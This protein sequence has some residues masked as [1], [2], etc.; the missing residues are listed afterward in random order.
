[1]AAAAL[2]IA[3]TE[4]SGAV[5]GHTASRS[6]IKLVKATGHFQKAT[7]GT[8]KA[9]CPGGYRVIGGGYA[10]AGPGGARA[11]TFVAAPTSKDN[12]YWAGVVNPGSNPLNGEVGAETDVEAVAYCAKVGVPIVP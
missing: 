1:V 11:F 4:S 9:H 7:V 6:T 2:A 10:N 5:V 3:F 12:G 8:V